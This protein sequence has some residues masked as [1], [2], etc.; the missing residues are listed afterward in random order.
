MWWAWHN[1]WKRTKLL[2]QDVCKK[3]I[4]DCWQNST[5]KMKKHKK[6]F[7]F[8]KATS[9]RLIW[10]A[11]PH[12]HTKQITTR[13]TSI[14][15]I[16]SLACV[17][18]TKAVTLYANSFVTNYTLEW[19]A[20]IWNIETD[21]LQAN[22]KTGKKRGSN[23]LVIQLTLYILS[24]EA[25]EMLKLV[26]IVWKFNFILFDN[27]RYTPTMCLLSVSKTE[28]NEKWMVNGNIINNT[29]F[30]SLKISVCS[31]IILFYYIEIFT[32]LYRPLPLLMVKI[33]GNGFAWN[34][35]FFL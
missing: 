23:N 9:K 5:R 12:T 11:V 14:V 31:S 21:T 17:Q 33:C 28:N 24:V 7:F 18:T 19:L 1:D 25:L 22:W 29:I 30:F 35:I 4:G 26:C 34:V 6:N 32:V 3:K 10:Q 16:R 8:E 27:V 15:P 20:N 2:Q 13:I